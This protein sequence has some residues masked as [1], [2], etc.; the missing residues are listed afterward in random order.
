M[1]ASL[2][3]RAPVVGAAEAIKQGRKVRRLSKTRLGL[4][5]GLSESYVGKIESGECMPSLRTF[6]LLAHALGMTAMEV[7]V[8]ILGEVMHATGEHPFDVTPPAY[9][10]EA[11]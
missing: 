7:Y 3:Q 1:A 4:N 8:V 5:A 10:R 9:G 6:A 11:V 2:T